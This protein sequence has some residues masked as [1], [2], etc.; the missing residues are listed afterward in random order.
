MDDWWL[1]AVTRPLGAYYRVDMRSVTDMHVALNEIG[2]LYASAICH[3]GWEEGF[4]KPS[5][6]KRRHWMI[7]R[8]KA[9]PADGGHAFAIV[10]YNQEGSSF[11]IHG[12]RAGARM[13]AEYCRMKTG[14][15]MRWIVGS[16]RWVSSPNCMW[17]LHTRARCACRTARCSLPV[18]RHY[19]NVRSAHTSSTWRTTDGSATPAIFAHRNPTSTRLS[20]TISAWHGPHGSAHTGSHRYRNL[21]AWRPHFRRYGGRNGG[22]MDSRVVRTPDFSYLPNVGKPTSGLRSRA[23]WRIS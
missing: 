15:T 13:A 14:S 12:G 4:A 8:R 11:I 20:R 19:A 10:G 2:I 3:P 18:S 1:D 7:P 6:A 22:E 5:P 17:K 9:G 21:R 16:P 23:G